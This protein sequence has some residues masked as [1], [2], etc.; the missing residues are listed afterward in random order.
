MH[1]LSILLFLLNKRKWS[2]GQRSGLR[3]V[4]PVCSSPARHARAKAT[5]GAFS[6]FDKCLHDDFYLP[7]NSCKS[8]SHICPL[9]FIKEF[10]MVMCWTTS[11]IS[12]VSPT[13]HLIMSSLS[14]LVN[15]LLMKPEKALWTCFTVTALAVISF[16]MVELIAPKCWKQ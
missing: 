14:L 16:S 7:R 2:V 11:K 13:V 5:S 1:I 4:G 8:K 3:S 10:L 12:F 9:S 15:S 6:P